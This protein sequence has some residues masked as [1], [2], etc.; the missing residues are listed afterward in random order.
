MRH[1]PMPGGS[2]FSIL[3]GLAGFVGTLLLIVLVA[4]LVFYFLRRRKSQPGGP[5]HYQPMQPTP[6]ALQILDQRLANGEIEIEDYLNRKTA[7]L[8]AAPQPA[9]WAPGTTPTPTPAPAE[10]PT[11]EDKG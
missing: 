10:Q 4:V 5:H 6:Q 8:A 11:Q 2:G 9:E 3:F 7:L 1:L